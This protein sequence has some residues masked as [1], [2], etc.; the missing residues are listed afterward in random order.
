MS[1]KSRAL[2][3]LAA[4]ESAYGVDPTPTA[5]ANAIEILSPT[6]QPYNADEI[7]RD[8]SRPAAGFDP[9]LLAGK[10]VVLSGQIELSG[11]GTSGASI[12]APAYGPILRACGL[13]ETIVTTVGQERVEYAPVSAEEESV[14]AYIYRAGALHRMTGARGT[15]GLTLTERQLPVFTFSL[16]GL[17]ETITA[18]PLPT[19]ADWSAFVPAV[20]MSEANT[21]FTLGGFPAVMESLSFS[22]NNTVI[23]RDRANSREIQ[24]TD[25]GPTGQLAI[26]APDP[27]TQDYWA[28]IDGETLVALQAVHG[29]TP[30]SRVQIDAPAVQL[31]QPS[32]SD[33]QGTVMLSANLR[34][35]RQAGD[36]E[37]LI[38]VS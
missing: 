22:A 21:Q 34:F 25:R 18:A 27:A 7:P 8:R 4:P 9:V 33:S 30:G 29:T 26:Q 35:N 16:T 3:V 17:F 12:A 19:N 6:L 14:T 2:V 32:Y 10:N 23:L 24:I 37:I 11:S 38:T 31:H 5:I 28:T 20:E 13:A 1:F 36:D 15:W